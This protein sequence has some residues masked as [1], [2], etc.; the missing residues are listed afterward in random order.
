MAGEGKGLENPVRVASVILLSPDGTRMVIGNR[1]ETAN[2]GRHVNTLS[3]ITRAVTPGRWALLAG[4]ALRL[5]AQPGVTVLE[6]SP[7][8]RIGKGEHARNDDTAMAEEVLGKLG[9]SGALGAG[10]ISGTGR[11]VLRT[12]GS[13]PDKD[14]GQSELTDMLHYRVVLDAGSVPIPSASEQ[15][16]PIEWVDASLVPTAYETGDAGV[17]NNPK[18]DESFPCVDGACIWG[19]A[20]ILSGNPS[21]ARRQTT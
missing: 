16:N 5:P 13:V 7:P 4:G 11:A 21:L 10:L 1:Q 14:T 20:I 8:F 6:N 17:F 18:L 2:E 19:A 15:Y 9:V 3:S 12:L